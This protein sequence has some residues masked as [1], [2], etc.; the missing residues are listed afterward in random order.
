MIVE[1]ARLDISQEPD[2]DNR[3]VLGHWISQYTQSQSISS[4]VIKIAF[5]YLK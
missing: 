4:M 3:Y 5:L 2:L 1:W